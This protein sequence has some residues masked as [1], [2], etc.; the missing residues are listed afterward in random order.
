MRDQIEVQ[1]Q[2]VIATILGALD[3]AQGGDVVGENG[4][5]DLKRDT[6]IED[7]AATAVR[8]PVLADRHAGQ[9]N[10]GTAGIANATAVVGGRIQSH[11]AVDDVEVAAASRTA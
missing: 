7:A 1:R 2:Q 4:V 8:R 10:D 3:T 11:R 5:L 6:A 9:R